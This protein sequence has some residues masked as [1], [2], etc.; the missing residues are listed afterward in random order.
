M[1]K[2]TF[3]DNESSSNYEMFNRQSTS[4][5]ENHF[6]NFTGATFALATHVYTN[7]HNGPTS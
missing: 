6:V 4:E 5:N 7:M 2:I 1:N 3:I